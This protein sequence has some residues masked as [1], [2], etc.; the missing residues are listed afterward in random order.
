MYIKVRPVPF[1]MDPSISWPGVERWNIDQSWIKIFQS[2]DYLSDK[3][4]MLK[5]KTYLR[6]NWNS[7]WIGRVQKGLKEESRNRQLK[8]VKYVSG[9]WQL[10]KYI[11]CPVTTQKD[12][13]DQLICIC[14]RQRR[15]TFEI[16]GK[17]WA[18]TIH[19]CPKLVSSF[20]NQLFVS[21]FL[22]LTV[23]NLAI[24]VIV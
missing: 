21:L 20:S 3:T 1:S 9:P 12:D 15:F 2:L 19:E 16:V 7:N 13:S 18:N 11:L 14:Y 10:L 17:T 22:K 6:G 24:L 4:N 23:A 5:S 8:R